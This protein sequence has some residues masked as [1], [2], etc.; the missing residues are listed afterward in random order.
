MYKTFQT[1]NKI[2]DLKM[3]IRKWNSKYSTDL[4]LKYNSEST[5]KNYSCCVGKFLNHFKEYREPKEIP[6]QEIK[7]YMLRFKTLNTRKHNLC[8]VNSFYKLS[9]GM[10]NKISRIPYPKKEK[11]LP[12]VI[13]SKHLKNTIENIPNLKHKCILSIG[14]GCGLRVSEVLNIQFCDIDRKRMLLHIRNAKGHKDRYVKLSDSIL[15]LIKKYYRSYRPK[16]Y[17][18]EG[19]FGGKYSSGSCNNIVKKY[20]GNEW[21]FH[22]LRHSYATALHEKGVDMA[23][24]SN[25]LGH[26]S[27]KTTMTYTHV[28]LN[29]IKNTP[30]LM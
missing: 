19:Q 11:K 20:L 12:K 28:S 24:L 22:T 2:N 17:L 21:H 9:V 6:T 10:P 3:N 13:D 15:N 27:I 18:F 7:E 26:N 16:E 14:F 29:S 23:T 25:L 30:N 8:A 4:R 5:I 1:I